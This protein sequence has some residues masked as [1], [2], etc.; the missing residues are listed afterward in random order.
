MDTASHLL[1]GVTL[2]G[3]AQLTL[4]LRTI[5]CWRKRSWSQR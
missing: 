4:P 5:R 1:L 3:L 2:A